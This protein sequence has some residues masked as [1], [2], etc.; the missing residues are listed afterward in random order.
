MWASESMISLAEST[1][2][3]SR[4]K[5]TVDQTRGGALVVAVVGSGEVTAPS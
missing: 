4:S 3:P 5:S 2:V 1:I